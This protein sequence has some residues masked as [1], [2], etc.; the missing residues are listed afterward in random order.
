MKKKIFGIISLILGVVNTVLT[1]RYEVIILGY[2][3]WYAII[4]YFKEWAFLVLL[5]VLFGYFVL[6]WICES[7][8]RKK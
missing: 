4:H 2:K 8:K 7:D 5:W 1:I 3:R 6:L